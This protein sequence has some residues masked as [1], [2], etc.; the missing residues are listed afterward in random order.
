MKR[1]S[2]YR[3]AIFG[4]LLGGAL[5]PVSGCATQEEVDEWDTVQDR[6]YN[7]MP[8]A[9][10][11]FPFSARLFFSDGQDVLQD[12]F[13]G[14]VLIKN[15]YVITAAHCVDGYVANAEA[16][17]ATQMRVGV[18]RLRVS[19]YYPNVPARTIR[20]TRA[21]QHPEW[22]GSDL[23]YDIAVLRLAEPIEG[24]EKAPL[25][26]DGEESNLGGAGESA[27]GIGHGAGLGANGDP[28]TDE[29]TFSDRLRKA[30]FEMLPQGVCRSVL[31]PLGVNWSGRLRCGGGGTTPDDFVSVCSGDSGGPL[32]VQKPN[33]RWRTLGIVSASGCRVEGGEVL[34]GTSTV[35]SIFVRGRT[36]RTWANDC[37]SNASCGTPSAI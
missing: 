25:V 5:A 26:N 35:P 32:L 10:G 4:M 33:G 15:R 21:W 7:G 20:V 8:A 9:G 24:A 16:A 18:G 1:R 27:V 12:G 30:D 28:A 34:T 22:D 36:A 19:G 14:G 6:I 23:G 29:F 3:S 31:E 13:C 17:G 11:E 37:V 2:G